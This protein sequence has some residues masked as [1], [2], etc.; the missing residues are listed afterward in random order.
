MHECAI[1]SACYW[2]CVF[3]FVWCNF[4]CDRLSRPF[5]THPH[6]PRQDIALY[7]EFTIS[8]TLW[9]FGRIHGL[10]SKETRERMKFLVEFLDLPQKN[11][12]VRNL[13]CKRFTDS[14]S[15]QFSL[16]YWSGLIKPRCSPNGTAMFRS[17]NLCNLWNALRKDLF[18]KACLFCWS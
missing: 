18:L 9:F 1:K 13:R 17:C 8:D 15:F 11:S 16:V 4:W 2:W 3:V 10:S 6:S 5:P 12:L 7:N 14:D